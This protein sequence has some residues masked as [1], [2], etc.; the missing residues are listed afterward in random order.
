M[1]QASP[2]I[3]SIDIE[4]AFPDSVDQER[5]FPIVDYLDDAGLTILHGFLRTKL[6]LGVI[7]HDR[8]NPDVKNLLT[9]LNQQWKVLERT[10]KQLRVDRKSKTGSV[11]SDQSDDPRLEAIAIL[12]SGIDQVKN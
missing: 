10:I 5:L 11:N 12:K 1:G 7:G 3:I 6:V 4:K 2:K 9:R 8:R